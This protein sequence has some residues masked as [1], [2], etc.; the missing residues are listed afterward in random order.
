MKD[1]RLQ[2]IMTRPVNTVSK[3]ATAEAAWE[4]MRAERFHHL[5]VLD[6]NKIVGILTDR[7]LG[8]PRGKNIRRGK[9]AGELMAVSPVTAEGRMTV[10]QA[11]NK[12]RG[13]AIGCLP[14]VDNGKLVG[15]VTV[16]DL[17]DVLSRGVDRPA[18]AERHL[19]NRRHPRQ[20]RTR[21]TRESQIWQRR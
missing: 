2:E 19:L 10:R 17:L 15:I 18:K 11:A 16:S 7:D 3:D 8:G 4:T 9:T 6:A 14:I 5:V 12:L 13:R 1:M 21:E 20:S